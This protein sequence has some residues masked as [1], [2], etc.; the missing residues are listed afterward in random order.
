MAVKKKTKIK[1][2]RKLPVKKSSS[3]KSNKFSNSEIASSL[4]KIE[5]IQRK[6]LNQ[7]NKILREEKSIESQEFREIGLEKSQLEKENLVQS[8][9]EQEI[10]ELQK[11]E[12]LEKS[13]AEDVKE[14]PLK[15]ITYRDITKGMIGAFFGIVGHF[16]FAEGAHIAEGFSYARSTLL[17]VTSFVIIVAFL[18]FSGFRRVDDD[19]VVKILPLRAIVIYVSAIA[20]ILVVLTIYGNIGAGQTF[21]EI[22]NN[23]AAVSILA[24]LGAGTADLIGK[25]E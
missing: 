10:S 3:D 9:E 11:V 12:E 22:Y 16:S 1:K 19:F 7:Q 8:E 4:R 6:I 14:S 20:T 24:V 5:N 2:G 21:H 17:F 18:Y 23:I 25:S 13:I 15:R